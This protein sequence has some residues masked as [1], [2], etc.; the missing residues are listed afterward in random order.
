MRVDPYQQ[1]QGGLKSCIDNYKIDKEEKH[2]N[3][4]FDLIRSINVYP[5]PF[6]DEEGEINEVIKCINRDVG[7]CI[8]ILHENNQHDG[9]GGDGDGENG[10]EWYLKCR[11]LMGLTLCRHIF[12]QIAYVKRSKKA[13]SVYDSFM[14][15][16]D[17]YKSLK[18]LFKDRKTCTAPQLHSVMGVVLSNVFNNYNCCRMKALCEYFCPNGGIVYDFSAGFGGRMLG[19]LSSKKVYRYIGVDPNTELQA[20]YK[21]M[22][23]VITKAWKQLGDKREVSMK[24]HCIGSEEFCPVELHNKVDFSFSSPAYWDREYYCDEE[25]QCYIKYP[26]LN[27][28]LENYARPTI[29]NIFRLLKPNGIVGFN[30]GDYGKVKF[31]EHWL[32]IA[33]DCG[34]EYQGRIISQKESR[35]GSGH[36]R[37]TTKT[38]NIYIFRKP[39]DITFLLDNLRI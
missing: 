1:I 25:T 18:F 3:D 5:T 20:G 21:K 14:N 13:K 35:I 37:N 17:L 15:D 4:A 26:K 38:E 16:N 27:D 12:P 29:Q 22:S 36:D 10:K 9:G 32:K 39:S 34:F 2:I 6:F 23:S 30:I 8:T 19:C 28:W 24:I 11:Y 7:D 33:S 31:V